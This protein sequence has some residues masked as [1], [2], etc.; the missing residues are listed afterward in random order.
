MKR[1][2]SPQTFPR[3][4]PTFD[5]IC[6]R[7]YQIW[8]TEGRPEGRDEENWFEAERQLTEAGTYEDASDSPQA[9][10]TAAKPGTVFS[11][12]NEDVPIPFAETV[13]LAAKM[14]KQVKSNAVRP[15]SR[16]S[17]TSF[18]L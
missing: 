3:R 4:T 9:G 6:R 10:D 13:P 2:I 15:E 14:E 5:E 1:E 12:E 17:K 11:E 18:E 16:N 8:E 7:A